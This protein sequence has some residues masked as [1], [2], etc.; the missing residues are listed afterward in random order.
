[1][2][3]EIFDQTASNPQQQ[4]IL[5]NRLKELSDDQALQLTRNQ[6]LLQQWMQQE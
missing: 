1:V 6:A 5:L 3:Q 4:T 2:R